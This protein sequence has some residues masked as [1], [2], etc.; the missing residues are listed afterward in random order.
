M[1]RTPTGRRSEWRRGNGLGRVDE[2]R[3]APVSVSFA[4]WLVAGAWLGRG[5]AGLGGRAGCE[6]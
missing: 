2:G 1:G 4:G 6:G 3:F 5:G